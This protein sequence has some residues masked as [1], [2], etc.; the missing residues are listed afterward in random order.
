M[1]IIIPAIRLI[2]SDE[3]AENQY[4]IIIRK[5]KALTGIAYP[6]YRMFVQ[7]QANIDKKPRGSV[8]CIDSGYGEKGFLD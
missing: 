6:G 4:S 8:E 2:S 7:G 5:F 1:V 3:A